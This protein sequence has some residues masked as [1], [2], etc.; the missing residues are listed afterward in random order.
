MP[1]SPR[2]ILQGRTLA[3][4][5]HPLRSSDRR[6]RPTAAPSDQTDDDLR[7]TYDRDD[8]ELVRDACEAAPE[9]R[10]AASPPIEPPAPLRDDEVICRSCRLAVRRR[11]PVGVVLLICD[12]CRW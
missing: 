5:E 9:L 4:Q 11:D 6:R 12:D 10:G 8:D 7:S 3:T 1:A 2:A